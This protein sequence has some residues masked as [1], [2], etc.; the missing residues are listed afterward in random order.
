M[1]SMPFFSLHIIILHRV[2][3]LKDELKLT[4][5]VRASLEDGIKQLEIQV[6]NRDVEIKRL[7][8][9]LDVGGG[10]QKLSIEHG[11]K[12]N[13]EKI[14]RLNA[15]ID[16]LTRENNNL[17]EMSKGLQK[18]LSRSGHLKNHNST[19]ESKL[20]DYSQKNDELR[21]TLKNKDRVLDKMRD[22]KAL[23]ESEFIEKKD[24]QI[25]AL[26]NEVVRLSK[27]LDDAIEDN[28]KLRL[29]SNQAG[30]SNIILI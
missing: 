24:Q 12:A 16:Y 11:T 8:A 18:D 30:T 6:M 23:A 5:E 10:D 13:A 4:S 2:N 9:K 17:E 22:S 25:Q 20:K 15:Q 3:T 19:L 14:N 21:A 28:S 29:E 7:Q 26:E 27:D 1:I